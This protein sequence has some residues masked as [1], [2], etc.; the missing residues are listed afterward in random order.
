VSNGRDDTG[1]VQNGVIVLDAG[2]PSLPEGTR[3]DIAP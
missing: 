2:V 3:V 1:Q